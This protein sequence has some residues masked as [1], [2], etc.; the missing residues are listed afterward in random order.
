MKV[1]Y[2]AHV[3]FD[4][5]TTQRAQALRESIERKFNLE[6]GR[7]HQK[8]VGPHPSWSFQIKFTESDFGEFVQWLLHNRK[9]LTIFIHQCSGD[10]LKDHTENV[11]WLGKSQNLNLEIFT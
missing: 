6:I 9:D 4:Q 7:F 10:N 11:C 3:Y 8:L 2:H 1:D 5:F